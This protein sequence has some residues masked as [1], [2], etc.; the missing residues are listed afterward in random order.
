MRVSLSL[1]A[2]MDSAAAALWAKKPMAGSGEKIFCQLAVS[3]TAASQASGIP[4]TQA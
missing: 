2:S 4:V 1:P 3:V